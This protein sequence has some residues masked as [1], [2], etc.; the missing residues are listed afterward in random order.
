MPVDDR[1]ELEK[2]F[3][4][5]KTFQ[6]GSERCRFFSLRLVPVLRR[7]GGWSGCKRERSGTRE[8]SR[9]AGGQNCRRIFLAAARG[10]FRWAPVHCASLLHS[11]SLRSRADRGHGDGRAWDALRV[12]PGTPTVLL[13][14]CG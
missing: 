12:L 2:F 11:L 8:A 7:S 6:A 13:P 3:G 1:E 5:R 14:C 10:R 4:G 9:N